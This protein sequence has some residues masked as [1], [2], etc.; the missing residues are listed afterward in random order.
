MKKL[1]TS[2]YCFV[3]GRLNEIGLHL[4]FYSPEPGK[5]EAV[6]TVDK[7]FQGY[8]GVVHGGIISAILDEI[9]G[10]AVMM[11]EPG[12]E[13]RFLVTARLDVRYRRPVPTGEELQVRG[14]LIK[15]TGRVATVKGEIFNQAGLLLAEAEGVM[16]NI[17]DQM[18]AGHDPEMMG[19]KVYPDEGGQP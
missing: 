13:T 1:A 4:E 10:R 7:R 5:V 17:P 6:T 12:K 9:S 3:C 15:D 2:S 8:P 19:W 16:V 18:L 14:H 11:D